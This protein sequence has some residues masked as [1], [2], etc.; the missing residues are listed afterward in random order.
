MKRLMF[1]VCAAAGLLML[2]VASTTT[3]SSVGR[4]TERRS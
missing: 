4:S 2:P 1:A 3:G